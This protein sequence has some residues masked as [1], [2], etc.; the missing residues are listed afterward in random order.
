M[1]NFELIV[2]KENESLDDF[3]TKLSNIVIACYDLGEVIPQDKLIKKKFDIIDQR[4]SHYG[5]DY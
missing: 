5:H 4:F 1:A 3:Y 2:R